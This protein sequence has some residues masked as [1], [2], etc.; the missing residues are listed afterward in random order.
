MK[1]RLP[2]KYALVAFLLIGTSSAAQKST[3]SPELTKINLATIGAIAPKGRVQ[4]AE[5][6]RLP[7][8]DQLIAHGRDSIPYLI[9]K[10]D[11]ETKIEGHVV[12][13]WHEVRVADIALIILTDFFTDHT[14]QNTT[15]PGIGWNQFLERGGNPDLTSEQ[16]LKNY[17][18]KHGRSRIK[19]RWQKI[20]ETY[21]G[22]I[23][24]DEKERC[25]QP[26]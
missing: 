8:V 24:W 6:N 25:F 10:L 5:Y 20:W 15:I 1:I 3:H 18:S 21:Q 19:Q 4:D 16:V 14:W 12:D 26:S 17:I 22:K 23:E 11:D 13:Y 9:S 2:V 7:L